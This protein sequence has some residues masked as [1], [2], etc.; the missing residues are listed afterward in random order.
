[1]D[2]PTFSDDHQLRRVLREATILVGAGYAIVLQVAHPG[3]GQGVYDHSDFASR[4]LDR[5]RGTLTFIYGVVFGTREEADQIG[6]IVRA[7]HNKVTGPGYHAL[8][9][10]LQLWVAATLYASALR[11]HELCVGALTEAQ[12]D[13]MYAQGAVF[14]TSL[15]CP[16][17]R[18]PADRVAFA[19]Y[20]TRTMQDM[21]TTDAT[22]AV[23]Q[24]LFL[25]DNA[26]LRPAA[27]AQR[28]IATG[29]LAPEL[30]EELSLAWSARHQRRFDRLFALVRAVYPRLPVILRTAP[31]NLYM[32]SMR[33]RA[34]RNRLYHRPKGHV[35]TLRGLAA[36]Q[37]AAEL[38]R[39]QSGV[40][41]FPEVRPE[42]ESVG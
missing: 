30:R 32:R 42:S 6:R 33:R 16:A 31:K 1:M 19:A 35:R 24:E 2:D 34:A 14:A 26:L 3:V 17:E 22:Q 38:Q 36:A 37:R 11:T 23:L 13:E 9:P 29:L 7:M 40:S 4:P 10:E 21:H 39:P 5:L 41:R 8:D 28:F 12:K 18:W 20:W 27:R 15:G 25:P